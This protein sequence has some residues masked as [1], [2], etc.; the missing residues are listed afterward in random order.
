[1]GQ[2]DGVCDTHVLSQAQQ[3]TRQVPWHAIPTWTSVLSLGFSAIPRIGEGRREG[4]GSRSSYRVRVVDDGLD[5]FLIELWDPVPVQ[6]LLQRAL[7]DR[8]KCCSREV[9][10]VLTLP[11]SPATSLMFLSKITAEPS[12]SGLKGI[13]NLLF[14]PEPSHQTV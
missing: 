10:L 5:C 1:M 4:E 12:I 11:G 7:S 13:N 2:T 14:M 3:S 6:L 8:C 9:N